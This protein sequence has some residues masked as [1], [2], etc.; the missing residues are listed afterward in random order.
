M[1]VVSTAI[2]AAVVA[3][4]GLILAWLGKGRFETID[5]RFEAQDR[6]IDQLEERLE[7][8]MDALQAS[9]DAMRSDLTQVALA[10]GVSRRATNA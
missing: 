8:R 1:E 6:R 5:R 4:V 7:R 2:N 10:V 3:T 9:V